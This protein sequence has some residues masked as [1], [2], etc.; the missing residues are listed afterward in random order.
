MLR[1]ELQEPRIQYAI[2]SITNLGYVVH[3]R[4]KSTIKFMFN[5]NEITFFPYTGWHSGKGIKDGRGVRNLLK[6][7]TLKS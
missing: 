1:E 5:G 4:D 3:Y 7:I 6:Q 2:E